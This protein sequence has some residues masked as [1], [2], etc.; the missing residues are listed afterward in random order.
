MQANIPLKINTEDNCKFFNIS[1][2]DINKD[3]SVDKRDIKCQLKVPKK[4][5][6]F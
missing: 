2:D 3:V 5:L 1:G 4:L 6:F